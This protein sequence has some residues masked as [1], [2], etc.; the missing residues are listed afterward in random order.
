MSQIQDLITM[1]Q[2]ALRVAEA[3]RV[4]CEAYHIWRDEYG[5]R[6]KL[7]SI[8]DLDPLFSAGSRVQEYAGMLHAHMTDLLSQGGSEE[9]LM[10]SY[11]YIDRLA[12]MVVAEFDASHRDA[13]PDIGP[14]RTA[15]EDPHDLAMAA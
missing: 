7:E 1:Q 9:L 13:A 6:E 14:T 10:A 4:D 11:D 5:G 12:E 15:P 3:S 2:V 8:L